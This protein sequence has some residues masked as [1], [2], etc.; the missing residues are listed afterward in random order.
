MLLWPPERRPVGPGASSLQV[1]PSHDT[2]RLQTRLQGHTFTN[3]E[4]REAC[5][6]VLW[7]LQLSLAQPEP[8]AGLRGDDA[9]DAGGLI[10]TN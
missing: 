10:L 6:P 9:A 5:E 3:E 2:W 8:L 1:L 4:P 7:L